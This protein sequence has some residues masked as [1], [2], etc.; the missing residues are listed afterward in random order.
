M[1]QG[2]NAAGR[3]LI[4]GSRR[5]GPGD[6]ADSPVALKVNAG[7]SGARAAQSVPGKAPPSIRRFWP[8]M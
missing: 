4:Q 3:R 2:A 7:A 8:V 6:Y 5:S 1:Q